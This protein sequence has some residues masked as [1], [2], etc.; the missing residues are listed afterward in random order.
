M[1]NQRMPK[2]ISKSGMEGIRK[3]GL[4]HKRRRDEVDK[5]F[6]IMGGKTSRH[7]P[8]MIGKGDDCIGSHGRTGTVA[9]EKEEGEEK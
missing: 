9:L 8:K 1:Q 4:P 3:Q 7:W 6:N 5:G 2:Q